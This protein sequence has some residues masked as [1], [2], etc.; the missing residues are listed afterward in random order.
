MPQRQ[1]YPTDWRVLGN[2]IY[3]ILVP[4]EYLNCGR[5]FRQVAT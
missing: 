2:L 5:E 1:T 3:A 4:Q